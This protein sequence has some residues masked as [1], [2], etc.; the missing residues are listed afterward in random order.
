[1]SLK[2]DYD[3][4]KVEGEVYYIAGRVKVR[5]IA[6]FETDNKY[7]LDCVV[8][9]LEGR[10]EKDTL[11]FSKL[12]R[13]KKERKK[14]EINMSEIEINYESYVG[15]DDYDEHHRLTDDGIFYFVGVLRHRGAIPVV[16]G[17][18][19]TREDA[20]ESVK[21]NVCDINEAGYYPIALVE[22]VESI[23]MHPI[24]PK[25]QFYKYNREDDK[26]YEIEDPIE[27]QRAYNIVV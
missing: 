25:R 4:I 13:L 5:L 15:D 14:T 1:M 19:P 6:I 27:Y 2:S 10:E 17:I 16:A 12:D 18:Y 23:G 9:P 7:D 20:V 21:D 26:Y 3:E 8:K 24:A 22:Q 11:Q